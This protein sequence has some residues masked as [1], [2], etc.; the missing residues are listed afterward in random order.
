MS[1]VGA[2]CSPDGRT[3]SP[4]SSGE[5]GVVLAT[6]P[7]RGSASASSKP[8]RRASRWLRAEAAGIWR[9]SASCQRRRCFLRAM[10]P[11]RLRLF[12]VCSRT[13][14]GRRF[15]PLEGSSSMS[16]SP[17][18]SRWLAC[19]QSTTPSL[20][21]AGVRPRSRRVERP[22]I[23]EVPGAGPAGARRLLTGAV[24][25]ALASKPIPHERADRAEPRAARALCRAGSRPHSRRVVTPASG[26]AASPTARTRSWPSARLPAAEGPAAPGRP[27]RRPPARAA[28]PRGGASA[29]LSSPSSGSTT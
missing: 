15:R 23:D 27:D 4:R 25:R 1:G 5:A 17:S 22:V 13:S 18:R 10:R 14:G 2:S 7:R 16:A 9:P 6:T 29:E 12:A 21:G 8:W 19:S 24:G 20:K 28:G 3:M 26:A 11:P